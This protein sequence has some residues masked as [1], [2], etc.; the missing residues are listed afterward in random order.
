[1][2][3][4]TSRTVALSGATDFS[5]VSSSPVKLTWADT[6]TAVSLDG[7]QMAAQIATLQPADASGAGTGGVYAEAAKAYNDVATALAT[8]VNAVHTTG[9]TSTGAAGG[10]FFDFTSTTGAPAANLVVVPTS[11]SGIAAADGTKGNY[12]NIDRGQ[13]RA[14]RQ[15]RRARRTPRGRPTCPGSARSP[16][17]ADGPSDD[18]D[19]GLDRRDHRADLGQR[20]RPRR[21]DVEPGD[22]PA[23]LPGVGAGHQHDQRRCSTR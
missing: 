2:S 3:G 12:D 9:T 10:K 23:R 13:D 7:G 15:H 14:D 16:Q 4:D 1:M 21:G 8:Q 19:H 20:R 22:L 5:Q 18:G 17:T 11:I 6:G